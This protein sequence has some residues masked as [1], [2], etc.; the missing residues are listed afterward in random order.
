MTSRSCESILVWVSGEG[1]V[2]ALSHR[3]PAV[4]GYSMGIVQ[5]VII[6]LIVLFVAGYF[7]R[8][9]FRA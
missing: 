4:G 5:I 6:V 2:A 3:V 7:G 1:R 9:R 8:G